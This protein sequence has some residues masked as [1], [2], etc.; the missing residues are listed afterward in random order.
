V[1]AMRPEPVHEPGENSPGGNN[2]NPAEH[3]PAARFSQSDMDNFEILEV[4]DLRIVEIPDMLA[5]H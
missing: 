4:M 5:L 3:D 1:C 2:G